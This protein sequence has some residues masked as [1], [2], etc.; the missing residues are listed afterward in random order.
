MTAKMS[1]P[2]FWAPQ[3]TMVSRP[4]AVSEDMD[5]R[6]Q[7]A[8]VMKVAAARRRAIQRGRKARWRR[9]LV[10]RGPLTRAGRPCHD[11]AA[12]VGLSRWGIEGNLAAFGFGARSFVRFEGEAVVG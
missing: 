11:W 8:R 7:T 6:V 5:L 3:K 12:E 2:T 4:S 1:S 10:E 9:G